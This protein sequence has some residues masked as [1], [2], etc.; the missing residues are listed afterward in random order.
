MI[1]ILTVLL[2][3]TILTGCK[4]KDQAIKTS[5]T[6]INWITIEE[7]QTLIK[8][9]PKKVMIDVYAVWCGPCKKMAKHTFQDPEVV[10]YINKNFYAV[11]F[12]AESKKPIKFLNKT[13]NNPGRT[14]QLALKIGSN[15]GQLSYPSIVY[16]DKEFNKLSVVPGYYE[17]KE[18]LINTKFFGD[19][20]YK[21]KTFQQYQNQF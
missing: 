1:R 21:K 12:N 10:A 7:A 16:F 9:A 13:Y 8:T 6:S 5:D 19:N 18:F 3:I 20:I 4:S 17:P 15:N 11:K 2:S 14:H